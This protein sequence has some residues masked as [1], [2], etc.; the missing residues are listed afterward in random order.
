MK[1]LYC[2]VSYFCKGLASIGIKKKLIKIQKNLKTL[3]TL[4]RIILSNPCNKI[5]HFVHTQK[6]A[7]P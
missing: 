3:I 7:L 1:S 2:T 5:D 6:C 4:D